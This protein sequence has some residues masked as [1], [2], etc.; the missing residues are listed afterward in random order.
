MCRGLKNSGRLQMSLQEVF[1]KIIAEKSKDYAQEVWAG[2]LKPYLDKQK[3][4]FDESLQH[5]EKNTD[6][7]AKAYERLEKL[8][9]ENLEME[10]VV[11]T[12]MD[13]VKI[14]EEQL[15]MKKRRWFR[16]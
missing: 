12:L 6:D 5:L 2:T 1:E 14:L 9:N 13:K 4:L 11:K 15:D 8:E 7:L 16:R 3:E 10:T